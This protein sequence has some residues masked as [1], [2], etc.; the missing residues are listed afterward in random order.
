MSTYLISYDLWWP[1]T[2]KDYEKL[3]SHI[4][5]YGTWAKPLESFWF[6]KTTKTLTTVRDETKQYLDSNDKLVVLDITKDNW[7]TIRIPKDVTER[8]QK[9]I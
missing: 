6:V 9:N 3:I 5:S 4:K 7:W 2:S 1:E 8:M